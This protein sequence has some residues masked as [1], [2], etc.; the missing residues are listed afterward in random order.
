M[1]EKI[2]S[3]L[4]NSRFLGDEAT[5]IVHDL[6]NEDTTEQGCFIDD[7]IERGNAVMFNPDALEEA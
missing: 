7:V 5:M 1:I 3:R 2:S 4:E 6:E